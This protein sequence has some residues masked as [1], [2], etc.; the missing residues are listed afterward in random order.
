VQ[1]AR[2]VRFGIVIEG[3]GEVEAAPLLIRRICHEICGVFNVH[4]ARPIRITKTT[5]VREGE[6][7]RAV[8]LAELAMGPADP[9]IILVDTDDD[10]PAE[11][12]PALKT[13]AL[14]VVQ[15]RGIATIVPKHEFESW[16]LAAAR[17]LAGKR[18]LS[19][20]LEPPEN[21]EG[22]RGAKEWLRGKMVPGRA[23]SPTVDQAAL[24]AEMDLAQ[25]RLSRSF[26][27]FV[28]EIERLIYD[29]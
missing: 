15:R 7:E 25:A 16:F 29:V 2:V 20:D 10:C 11:L 14:S 6:L 4:T 9:I 24:A 23:Y 19:H 28:R 5:L 12:G 17:S 21:P 8:R 3:K 18:G 26:D 1:T 27:S 13:R 22:I